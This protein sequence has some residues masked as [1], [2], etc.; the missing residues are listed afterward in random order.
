MD[1]ASLLLNPAM[2][3]IPATPHP[4]S[5][6]THNSQISHQLSAPDDDEDWS[7]VSDQRAR[8]RIQNRIAQR[9]YRTN[10]KR[11]IEELERQTTVAQVG[12]K[13]SV[14]LALDDNFHYY[15][16]LRHFDGNHKHYATCAYQNQL[17]R[18]I[19][20]GA[21]LHQQSRCGD[22]RSHIEQE[23]LDSLSSPDPTATHPQAKARQPNHRNLDHIITYSP[24][25][26]NRTHG[27]MPVMAN[28]SL[29]GNSSSPRDVV[30]QSSFSTMLNSL[31]E[32]FDRN[33]LIDEAHTWNEPCGASY[34][35]FY[36]DTEENPLASPHEE[37]FQDDIAMSYI[38]SAI[39]PVDA[40]QERYSERTAS[41]HPRSCK[42]FGEDTEKSVAETMSSTPKAINPE[43]KE[44]T[45]NMPSV[46]VE[47]A[48]FNERLN[49]LLECS[50][51]V[52]FTDFD[53]VISSYYTADFSD[54]SVVASVQRL[55][56]RR[57]L[58]KVLVALRENAV[59]WTQWEAQGY[60][61]ETFKSAEDLLVAECT[62]REECDTIIGILAGN[63][64]LANGHIAPV[65]ISAAQAQKKFQVMLPNLWSL[66]S[67]L[68][69]DVAAVH[70][71]NRSHVILAI[72]SLLYL[73]KKASAKHLRLWIGTC[74]NTGEK[75][76]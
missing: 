23:M 72:V 51:I 10:L 34:P 75:S 3:E 40:P 8:K 54:D 68:T 67:A 46:P 24:A 5:V 18:N 71:Q 19:G 70:S 47:G 63:S 45:A 28:K 29:N 20:Y 58:P 59:N 69:T 42:I 1:F 65:E 26:S 73:S 62:N 4:T 27:S 11:R 9:N 38:D 52:G 60:L 61:D 31:G 50:R 57:G 17:P 2:S 21:S 76:D 64:P 14:G 33:T 6:S 48:S 25:L 49:F 56:R 22:P 41:K 13:S 32:D 55:S 66:V 7:K 43:P 39:F 74:L 30:K 16:D 12:T 37:N 35:H 44:S 36:R 53:S 15:H